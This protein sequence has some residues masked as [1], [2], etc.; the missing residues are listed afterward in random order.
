MKT[1]SSHQRIYSD[2]LQKIRVGVYSSGD[3]LPS[4]PQMAREYSVSVGTLRKAVDRLELEGILSRQQGRGT[5][6]SA[7]S[8]AAAT[9]AAGGGSRYGGEYPEREKFVYGIY[10]HLGG[11][12]QVNEVLFRGEENIR[13]VLLPSPLDIKPMLS[14]LYN[15]CSL[16]QAPLAAFGEMQDFFRPLPEELFAD[17]PEYLL[18]EC[19]SFDG[20]FRFLPMLANNTFCYVNRGSAAKA[21]ITLPGDKWSLD[22]LFRLCQKFQTAIPEVRPLG[23]IPAP[24][25]WYD[26]LL[27][28]FGGDFFDERNRAWF[29]E[30]AFYSVIDF[31]R[32]LEEKS[33]S[34]NLMTTDR[35]TIQDSFQKQLFQ[36]CFYGPRGCMDVQKGTYEVK[37]LPE[38]VGCCV[39]FGVGIPYNAPDY[40]RALQMLKEWLRDH[41]LAEIHS[42]A[43]A[44]RKDLELWCQRQTVYNKKKLQQIPEK[45]HFISGRNHWHRWNQS[46]YRLIDLTVSGVILPE[47][48][49]R[50]IVSIL[51]N[52]CDNVPKYPLG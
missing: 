29:P 39:I 9:A 19:R 20:Q 25:L 3:R 14:S 6:V 21:G 47:N 18:S 8:N 38:Q 34:W 35:I 7:V 23:V 43:P 12:D 27:W 5:F 15:Q 11:Q 28:Q 22:D 33:L 40:D 4:E 30:K 31:C 41:R 48:A 13:Q 42:A 16:I 46:V 52:S 50:D 37:L 2:I 36:L 24:S 26:I 32:E 49:H 44:G 17:I 51:Q 45:L 10:Q 1:V